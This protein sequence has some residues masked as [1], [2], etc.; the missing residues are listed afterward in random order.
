MKY[1]CQNHKTPI[2]VPFGSSI[3]PKCK[4]KLAWKSSI[5]EPRREYEANTRAVFPL[6]KFVTKM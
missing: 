4:E 5:D 3:C 2:E 1:Y 6:E